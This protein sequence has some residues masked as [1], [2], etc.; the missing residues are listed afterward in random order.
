MTKF[1]ETFETILA[2]T[3]N[4][5]GTSKAKT[6]KRDDFDS[7]LRSILNTSDYKAAS[8]KASKG[9]VATEEIEV[10]QAVRKAFRKVLLDFG[11]DKAEAD[12]VLTSYEFTNVDGFYELISETIYQ[13]MNAGKKFNFLTKNDFQGSLLLNDVEAGETEHTD[14]KDRTKKIRKSHKAHKV[15]VRKSKT[16]DWLQTRL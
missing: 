1:N 2:S 6:F 13:Y 5:D 14:V 8:V 10:T 15:L 12:T 9:E 11:V 4:E 3:R 16:P 7:I